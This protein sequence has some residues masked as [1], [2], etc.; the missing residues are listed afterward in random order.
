MI[1]ITYGHVF[2][3]ITAVWLILRY[4]AIRKSG[5][6]ALKH[7]LKMLLV[8]IC[9]V[10]I[11]RFVYFGLH[12]VDGKLSTLKIGFSGNVSDMVSMVPFFFLVDR[13]DG[14]QIN[15][16]GNIAMFIPVGIVWPICFPRL[17]TYW[18]A[19]LA[20]GS[21]SLFIEVTQLICLERHTDIDD[22]ILNTAGAAIGTGIVFMVRGFLIQKKAR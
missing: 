12:L 3:F 10:V 18:K 2:A 11:A 9:L 4:F 6:F 1:E 17:N 16:I 5:R 13:Y 20:G 7:E 14:W 19:V 8:Y 15:I 22:L 21:L